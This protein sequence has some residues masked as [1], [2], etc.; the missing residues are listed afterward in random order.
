MPKVK[1]LIGLV[2][3]ETALAIN[4]IAV[5]FILLCADSSKSSISDYHDMTDPR[6]FFVPLTA[7]VM[8]LVTNG[9]VSSERHG[10]NA[11]LGGL[12]L[13][14]ILVDHDGASAPFHTVVAVS[15][16]VLSLIAGTLVAADIWNARTPQARKIAGLRKRVITL[17]ALVVLVLGAVTAVARNNHPL[18]WFE[19]AGLILIAAGHMFH[20]ILEVVHPERVRE[21]ATIFG[22][23]WPLLHKC[24]SWILRPLVKL[25]ERLNKRRENAAHELRAA[26]D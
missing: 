18:F 13:G 10:L 12:L 8:M 2:R 14:V 4:L 23:F 16:Y 24:L 19:A 17:A 25:W 3:F 21:P 20:S 11:L 15:F 1:D 7:A 22:D 5:P 9:L 6:W 26:A